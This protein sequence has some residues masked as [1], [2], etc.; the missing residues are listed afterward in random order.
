MKQVDC[1]PSCMYVC[2]FVSM[3]VCMCVCVCVCMYVCGC[4][5]VYICM[6]LSIHL[7]SR[8]PSFLLRHIT[9]H[10][11]RMF[12]ISYWEYINKD[13]TRYIKYIKS[14][15]KATLL[16]QETICSVLSVQFKLYNSHFQVY[17]KPGSVCHGWPAHWKFKTKYLR[18]KLPTQYPKL[19]YGM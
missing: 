7:K 19:V 12:R 10:I 8:Q 4:V 6:Y 13:P 5:C 15:F 3:Y 16:I 14:S 9:F 2:M 17:F 1:W 11:I 18:I